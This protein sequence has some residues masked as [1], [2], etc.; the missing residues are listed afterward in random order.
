MAF[1]DKKISKYIR[2]RPGH[3]TG[4][5]SFPRGIILGMLT[6]DR[7]MFAHEILREKIH[8]TSYVSNSQ[9]SLPLPA[10]SGLHVWRNQR[11]LISL[12]DA[13]RPG[14]VR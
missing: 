8:S 12:S 14:Q 4:S 7:N 5:H 10:K 1:C 3:Q 9:G 13:Q 2:D 6:D 11:D